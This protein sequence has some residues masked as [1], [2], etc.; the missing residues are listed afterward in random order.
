MIR[1]TLSSSL[2][3][4]IETP[5]VSLFESQPV[6]DGKVLVGWKSQVVHD[7]GE[8]IRLRYTAPAPDQGAFVLEAHHPGSEGHIRLRYWLEEFPVE[9]N[10]EMMVSPRKWAIGWR[11]NPNLRAG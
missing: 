1:L 4:C 10:F 8:R 9:N 3:L 7:D 5:S 2:A 11:S 6:I